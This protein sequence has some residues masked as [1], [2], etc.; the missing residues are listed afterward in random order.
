[1]PTQTGG[2]A[3]TDYKVEFSA[4]NGS[5]WS[6]FNDGVSTATSATVTGLTNGVTYSFRVSAVNSA[7][8]SPT[9]DVAR[10]A[11][12]VPTAPT[13]LSAV[14][15]AAQ[16]TLTWT[17]P[18]QTGGSAITDYIIE[19]SNDS[20]SS[21]TVFADGT[22]TATSAIV[23]GLTNGITH[24]FRVSATNAVGTGA[25]SSSVTAV[26]WQVNVPSAPRD[27][28]ITAVMATSISLEWRIPTIDGGGF[29]T[30]YVV[31]QSGDGG[32]TW[33]TS[34]VT[35]T[36]GRAGGIWFTTVYDLVS[37]R[38][39]RFRVRATNSAGNSEPS[40]ATAARAPGVPSEPED[41]RAVS[42][43]PRR[44]SLRWERPTS[45]GGVSLRGYTIDYSTDNGSSWTTWPQ[46]TG[47]VGCTCQ[48]MAR[49]VTDLTDGV[50]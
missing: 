1:A 21:W 8:T 24:T 37:G 42:A 3:I 5:T 50:A 23:T 48:Y 10:A 41:V 29:I 26:P 14:A 45:D 38:D 32:T 43:G 12:G 36:G 11:V 9:S 16:V 17:T 35:G 39:Y 15:G 18:S 19:F 22:S 2:G 34:L 6:T 30:G 28:T 25:V 40:T 46:D 4:N 44:I 20:G 7:G 49:T 31:E 47:V 27:L 13:G 33:F